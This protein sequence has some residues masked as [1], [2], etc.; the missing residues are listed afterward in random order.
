L[1]RLYFNSFFKPFKKNFLGRRY[2]R[3]E[4]RRRPF[5][6][7]E[8]YLFHKFFWNPREVILKE[9]LGPF[10]RKELRGSFSQKNI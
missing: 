3:K 5:I 6:F 4:G 7:G 8:K 1:G 9:F 2:L 10:N